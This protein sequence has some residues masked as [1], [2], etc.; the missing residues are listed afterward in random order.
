MTELEDIKLKMLLQ[1]IQLES[2]DANFSDRVMKKILQENDA[3][4]KIK[5]ERVLGKGFWI[6][7]ALFIVLLGIVGIVSSSGT[8][9]AGIFDKF[10]Q[11]NK[12]FGNASNT[13]NNYESI[14]EKFG[15]LPVGVAVIFI[16]SSI[17]LFIERFINSNLNVFPNKK[18]VS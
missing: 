2:P 14:L 16:A 15:S 13:A 7:V 4:E 11:A 18:I 17:L 12:I 1:D 10:F 3:I 6:I 9:T 5:S 8:E